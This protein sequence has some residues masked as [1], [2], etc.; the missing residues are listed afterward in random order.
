MIKEEL[1]WF[2]VHLR[3]QFNVILAPLY[4]FGLFVSEGDFDKQSALQFCIIHIFLYGGANSINSYYDKDSG[5]IGGSI[6]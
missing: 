5:P 3:L 2:I 1:L 6:K 4:L